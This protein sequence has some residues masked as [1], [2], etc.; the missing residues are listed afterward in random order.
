MKIAHE[1]ATNE[2]LLRLFVGDGGGGGCARDLVDI[3]AQR[4][5]KLSQIA[6]HHIVERQRQTQSNNAAPFS[7]KTPGAPA[8]SRWRPSPFTANGR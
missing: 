7:R 2:Q 3:W 4:C 5:R 8:N 1:R 6:S